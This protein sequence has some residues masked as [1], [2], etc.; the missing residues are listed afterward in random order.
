MVIVDSSNSYAFRVSMNKT[1]L[2]SF[3]S[4]QIHVLTDSYEVVSSCLLFTKRFRKIRLE[5]E[6]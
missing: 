4:L 1:P 2:R 5:S 3:Y 6:H